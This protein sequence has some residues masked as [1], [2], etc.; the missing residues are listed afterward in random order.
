MEH[1]PPRPAHYA[2][3]H[4]IIP[5]FVFRHPMMAVGL[6]EEGRGA[7]SGKRSLV[8]AMVRAAN[9]G[10]EAGMTL[11][12]AS[13]SVEAALVGSR[14]CAVI[15]FPPPERGSEAF[16]AAAVQMFDVD[17]P[18]Q[19]RGALLPRYFV[20]EYSPFR[21]EPQTL[22]ASWSPAGA[23]LNLGAGPRP[24]TAAFVEA[25]AGQLEAE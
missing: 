10:V 8:D 7:V 19:N 25:I 3:A 16:L 17:D 13:V 15:R 5:G 6:Y 21:P 14:G 1:P 22:L 2:L 11:D 20:L 24:T 18:P 23:H 9:Q 12:A 4:R